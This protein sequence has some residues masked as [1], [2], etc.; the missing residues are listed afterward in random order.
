M[1]H[2][3]EL[4]LAV[5]DPAMPAADAFVTGFVELWNAALDAEMPIS[6]AFVRHNFKPSCGVNAPPVYAD[7]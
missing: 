3:F 1:S 7:P 4:E 6:A 2:A 5:F